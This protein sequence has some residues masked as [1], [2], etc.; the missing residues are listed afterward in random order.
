[1]IQDRRRVVVTGIGMITPLGRGVNRSWEAVLR[2][3]NAVGP[4][5]RFDASRFPVQFAAEV[6]DPGPSVALPPGVAYLAADLKGRLAVAAAREALD[7]AGLTEGGPR[8]GVCIGSEASRPPLAET[9][10]QVCGGIL[11]VAHD[12]QRMSPDAPTRFLSALIGATGP[13]STIST[14]CTSSSQAVGEGMLSIRRGDADAMLVGGVDVLVDPIMVTGFSLLGALSTRNDEP[15][16]ASRPFDIGRDGFVLGEGAGFLV[17]EERGRAMRRGATILGEL[18]GF[19]CSC[20]AYRITDSPP[21][22]R[23]AGSAMTAGLLDAGLLPEEIGYI[24]AHGTSTP[25]NDA[26]E[27]RGIERAFGHLAQQVSVSSTKSMMGHLV[28]AC[29]AAILCVLAVRD[30]IL[31]PTINLDEPD[32]ACALNHVQNVAHE[33][34]IR[35]AMTNAFGFGGSNGTLVVSAP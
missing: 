32:P 27:T 9:S 31:P 14:A 7:M 4:I 6:A 11:P 30:G 34:R 19:G 18:S 24:N 15:T 10:A 25:M 1:M 26:S 28:A 12:L 20:N 3:E 22:G 13:R 29:G 16:R 35:H 33:R 17:L 23:G 2:G 21:D 8:V 5:R